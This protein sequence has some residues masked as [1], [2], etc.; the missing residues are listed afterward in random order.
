MPSWSS[1]E[2]ADPMVI[3]LDGTFHLWFTGRAEGNG[4]WIIGYTS[5]SDGENWRVR[6]TPVLQGGDR[7]WNAAG[8]AGPSVLFKDGVYYM[9][10]H[11]L[12]KLRDTSTSIGLST[13]SDGI[14]WTPNAANPV[15]RP[16]SSDS[17]KSALVR[18]PAVIYSDRGFEMYFVGA[19]DTN[20]EVANLRI[21]YARSEDGV[22]WKEHPGNPILNLGAQGSW[23]ADKILAP[24]I[25]LI[26]G[27]YH[28]WYTG[29]VDKKRRIGHAT[30]TDGL[31]WVKDPANPVLGLGAADGFASTGVAHPAMLLGPAGYHLWYVGTTGPVGEEGQS[32]GYAFS[33]DGTGWVR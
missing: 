9:W 5:S 14:H 32:I 21:G 18:D 22:R 8:V 28:M 30:S 2:V 25:L 26:E 4:E 24:D 13:S 27:K 33:S 31:L 29:E 12:D 19:D 16:S 23:E 6:S 1:F 20:W 17:W 7:L 11:G 15:I 3:Y 10:Y